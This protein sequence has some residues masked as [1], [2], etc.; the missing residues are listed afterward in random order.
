MYPSIDKWFN[1]KVLPGLK[2]SER[3]GY[4]GYLNELPVISSVLK[5][6][7][8]AKFCHLKI[9]KSLQDDNLG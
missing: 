1:N 7:K 2:T 5:K 9:D 4:I 8:Q 6:G 3:V